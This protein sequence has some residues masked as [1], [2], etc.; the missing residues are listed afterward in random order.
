MNTKANSYDLQSKWN[1]LGKGIAKI[2]VILL[3]LSLFCAFLPT[4]AWAEEAEQTESAETSDIVQESLAPEAGRATIIENVVTEP[5]ETQP[6]GQEKETNQLEDLLEP[7]EE[8]S[9]LTFT[10]EYPAVVQT[11]V[12]DN[13]G[14]RQENLLP[15]GS[16]AGSGLPTSDLYEVKP[17]G[18]PISNDIVRK[19]TG[20]TVTPPE[21]VQEELKDTPF[22][23]LQKN[24]NGTPNDSTDDTYVRSRETVSDNAINQAIAKALE[25]ATQDSKYITIAVTAGV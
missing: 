3:C 17:D 19:D 20:E 22:G 12:Y 24:D 25:S 18:V 1:R 4:I 13:T 15:E 11:E 8:D 5:G 23:A 10:N 7:G 9:S 2:V 6:S 16:T 21:E 14:V